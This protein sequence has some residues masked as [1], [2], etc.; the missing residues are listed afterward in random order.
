MTGHGIAFEGLSD[1][2]REVVL[3]P[4]GRLVFLGGAGAGKSLV[5]AERAARLIRDGATRP[6]RV[7]ILAPSRRAAL[8]LGERVGEGCG[9][10]PMASSFHGFAL[11]ILRRC[12]RE[13]GYVHLPEL[14][15]R[16][17]TS[18][19]SEASSPR[20]IPRSGPITRPPWS[21]PLSAS[22]PTTS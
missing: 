9:A 12:Y 8:E 19:C 7:L 22:S 13:M 3:A 2:Q 4:P 10:T 6:D 20:R 17:A 11:A 21:R 16:P 18:T 14:L 5:V 15:S 1:V